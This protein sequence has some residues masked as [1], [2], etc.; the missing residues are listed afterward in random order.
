LTSA[1]NE[2]GAGK[3]TIITLDQKTEV[4]KDDRKI[5]VLPVWEW[6]LV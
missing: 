3:L 4:V 2:L 1:A 6:M 5:S